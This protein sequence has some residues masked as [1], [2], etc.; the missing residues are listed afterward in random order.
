MN[1]L[2]N[3]QLNV[4]FAE[5]SARYVSYVYAQERLARAFAAEMNGSG[6]GP[7]GFEFEQMAAALTL[8]HNADVA[9]LAVL[10]QAVNEL[11]DDARRSSRWRAARS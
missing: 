7:S 8:S 4:S 6:E 2:L 3:L 10:K 9:Y 11:I 1:P 5:R